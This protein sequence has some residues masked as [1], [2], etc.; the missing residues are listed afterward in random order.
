[1][2]SIPLIEESRQIGGNPEVWVG[3]S[4]GENKEQRRGMILLVECDTRV[5]ASFQSRQV[6]SVGEPRHVNYLPVKARN[7]AIVVQNGSCDG[8]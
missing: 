3:S 4:T 8:R 2:R 7:D 1:M 5:A 6:I